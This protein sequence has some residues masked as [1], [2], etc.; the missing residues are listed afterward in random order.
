M[1]NM[2]PE[3]TAADVEYVRATF[4]EQSERERQRA[5]EGLAPQASYTLPDGT[6][7]VSAAPDAELAD[8]RDPDDLRRRFD[9]RW[10]AAGGDPQ[11]ADSELRAWLNGGYGVCLRS[12]G[13]ESILVKDGLARAITALVARPIPHEAWWRTTLRHAVAAYDA[14]V[15]PF[16][17]VD[18]AR[19]GGPSSRTRLVDEVRARW[20]DVFEAHAAAA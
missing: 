1:R 11:E 9:T 5:D 19:F 3:L 8:A 15:L 10:A 16:A 20:P 13:P 14:L 6:G 7:M 12:P 4:R 18:S 2:H 17:S